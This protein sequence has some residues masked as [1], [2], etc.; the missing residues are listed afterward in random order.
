MANRAAERFFA[1]LGALI[2]RRWQ[3]HA[4]DDGVFA[5]VALE[6]LE[7]MPPSA[8]LEAS[9]L[10]RWVLAA[11]RLPPQDLSSDFGEPPLTVYWHDHF[12]IEAL[13]WRTAHTDVHEHSFSGAFHLLQG[14][15]LHCRYRF[16]L[17]RRLNARLL[18]GRIDATSVE[19]L[20]R[21]D[22]RRI[23][24]GRELAHL[25]CHLEVPTVT[26]VVRT[27]VNPEALPQYRYL[28]P[29][30]VHDPLPR[31][32]VQDRRRALLELLRTTDE[33]TYRR[34]LAELAS[35]ADFESA[36]WL[37]ADAHPHVDPETRELLVSRVRARHGALADVLTPVFRENERNRDIQRRMR[38]AVKAEHRLLLS[39]LLALP[40]RRSI[41]DF[42]AA[43]FDGDPIDTIVR[44]ST[45]ASGRGADGFSAVGV[46]FDELSSLVFESVLRG[47]GLNEIE[48]R[49]RER[50]DAA[51]VEARRGYLARLVAA[52]HEAPLLSPLFVDADV[53][54]P[55]ALPGRRWNAVTSMPERA[56]VD[57]AAASG[58][59][60]H[61]PPEGALTPHR[62]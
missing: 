11:D 18:V 26:I 51:D 15:S 58:A 40:D 8:E 47:H 33:V 6:A 56:S 21:G 60:V 2:E 20:F 1:A 7:A 13:F 52:F 16:E 45:D 14:A 4:F 39:L 54:P 5:D 46:R 31:F 61:L 55:V 22:S 59:H 35:E 36:F 44:W 19:C 17:E 9:D 30:V 23:P 50:Y 10:V 28:R 57:R 27:R 53:G 3:T 25:T 29:H 48:E 43:H 41:L 32:A 24:A 12:Y 34:D 37:L 49:L 42:V 38:S 62:R